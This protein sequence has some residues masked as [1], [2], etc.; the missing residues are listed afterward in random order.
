MLP[1]LSRQGNHRRKLYKK[2]KYNIKLFEVDN[3]VIISENDINNKKFKD[4]NNY[5]KPVVNNSDI[6][7]IDD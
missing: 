5:D 6:G 4:I 7:F 3:N 1:S 2:L